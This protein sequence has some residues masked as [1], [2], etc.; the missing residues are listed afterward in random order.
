MYIK[1]NYKL[2]FSVPELES[3]C[4][5]VFACLQNL[6]L[7]FLGCLGAIVECEC[8]VEYSEHR[9]NLKGEFI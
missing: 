8:A 6:R 5:Q 7:Q 1:W 9:I 3:L 4:N 2:Q